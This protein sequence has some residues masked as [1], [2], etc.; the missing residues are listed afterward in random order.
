MKMKLMNGCSSGRDVS[1]SPHYEAEN[2]HQQSPPEIDINTIAPAIIC[3]PKQAIEQDYQ[4]DQ[5]NG[6]TNRQRDRHSMR[7]TRRF[8]ITNI[9]MTILRTHDIILCT[10]Q[11]KRILNTT[12]ITRAIIASTSGL[13]YQTVSFTSA[14]GVRL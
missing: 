11:K 1:S 12:R 10:H 9:L 5:A 3:I 6:G 4:P 2:D 14:F 7:L 13:L 8:H